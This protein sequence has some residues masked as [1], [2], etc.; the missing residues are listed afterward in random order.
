M[1]NKTFTFASH[2]EEKIFKHLKASGLQ[3]YYEPETFEYK[4]RTGNRAYCEDCGSKRT[5]KLARYTPD[6]RIGESIYL[7]A[8]GYF[9]PA[10]RAAM[11]DFLRTHPDFDLRFVFG[12]DNWLTSKRF[13]KY[14]DWAKSLK[15]K[16]A[17]G[18]VPDKWI[19]EAKR[20]VEASRRRSLQDN[21]NPAGGVHIQE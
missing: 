9:K 13:K 18:Q 16:Y 3:V 2:F 4:R 11:E 7:E 1:T 6:F 20:Q 17:I 19:E 21:G 15:V 14:S 10:K 8:K 12:A 5:Y